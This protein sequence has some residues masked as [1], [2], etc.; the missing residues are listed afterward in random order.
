MAS[1]YTSTQN[2][3]HQLIV[4]TFPEMK[5]VGENERHKPELKKQFARTYLLPAT[6][7]RETLGENGQFRYPGIFQVSFYVPAQS[8]VAANDLVDRLVEV[9]QTQPLFDLGEGSLHVLSAT[10]LPSQTE[11]DWFHL[12]VRLSYVAFA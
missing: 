4:D 9:V 7:T 8:G 1:I 12:P 6:T 2:T 10:R 3:L 5:V 11:T